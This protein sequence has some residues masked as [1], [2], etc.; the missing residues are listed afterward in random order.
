[1]AGRFEQI[2]GAGTKPLI[3]MA[4]LGPLPGT[5]L[6]DEA[7]GV[8]GIVD[9]VARDLDVLLQFPF[10]AV[11]FCNEGDR[12]Y[13]LRAGF[14]GVAVMAR[15]AAELAPGRPAVRRR[16]PLGRPGRAGRRA[17][18]GAAFIREVVTGAYESDMGVGPP[19]PATCCATG[20]PSA[21]STSR[22]S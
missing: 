19:T 22:C 4:H 5:P 15:V 16:L 18:T 8:Q 20:A 2:F 1:M 14:E 11:M 13:S 12:P 10:D 9:G 7:R 21:P 3:A 17:A 6:Y